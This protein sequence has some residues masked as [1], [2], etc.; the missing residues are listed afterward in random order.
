MTRPPALPPEGV[1][2]V[3]EKREAYDSRPTAAA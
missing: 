3:N 2:D 1:S